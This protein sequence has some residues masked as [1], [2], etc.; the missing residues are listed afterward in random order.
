MNERNKERKE[1]IKK[2]RTNEIHKE[3]THKE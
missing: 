2:E 3:R 1:Y